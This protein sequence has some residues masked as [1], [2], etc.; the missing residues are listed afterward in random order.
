M[1][2]N[3]LLYLSIYIITLFF[4]SS[5]I[6]ESILVNVYFSFLMLIAWLGVSAIIVN[7]IHF[8][9]VSKVDN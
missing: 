8:W 2:R 3:S 6:Y 4:F 5:P 9:P 7:I 1:K